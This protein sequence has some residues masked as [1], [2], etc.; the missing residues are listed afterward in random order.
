MLIQPFTYDGLYRRR[1]Y[2]QDMPLL[3]GPETEAE[4]IALV[5]RALKEHKEIQVTVKNYRKD[6]SWFWNR[7]ML[8]PV[9]MRQ[10]DVHIFGNS[11]RY[12]STAYS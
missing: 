1:C 12:Y 5:Q 2:G 10:V 11:G 9:L 3:Q 8:G 7:L 4:K 6:G